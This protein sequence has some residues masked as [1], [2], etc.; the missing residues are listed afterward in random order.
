M[1]G[2]LFLR[3][4]P[5]ILGCL[6]AIVALC[7]LHASGL[8]LSYLRGH[9][10]RHLVVGYFPQWGIYYPQP[11]YVKMLLANGSAA[12]LD[13]INY[14]QGSVGGGRCSLADPN[15]DL[16]TT[17]HGRDQRQRPGGRRQF[18]VSRLFPPT[19]RI[20]EPLPSPEDPDFARRQ[21]QRLRRGRQT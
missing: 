9:A 3:L 17:L 4:K 10:A 7:P 11:Y 18:A 6:L 21:G 8:G 16:N 2:F 5:G 12:H 20:E 1:A 15:A 13:Q 19:E 14:A